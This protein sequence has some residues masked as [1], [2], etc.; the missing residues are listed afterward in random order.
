M[1]SLTKNETDNVLRQGKSLLLHEWC[2]LWNLHLQIQ[3]RQG[4]NNINGK[5]LRHENPVT[6]YQFIMTS[7]I[8]T[9]VF[10]V[11]SHE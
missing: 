3:R 1:R 11:A 6:V 7:S 10:A 8:L 9:F 4:F 5:Q 2:P